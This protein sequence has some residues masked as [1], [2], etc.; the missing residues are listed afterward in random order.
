MT[1]VDAVNTKFRVRGAWFGDEN[2]GVEGGA[3]ETSEVG[4]STGLVNHP[5]WWWMKKTCRIKKMNF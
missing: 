2:L 1:W 3:V 5:A 4:V